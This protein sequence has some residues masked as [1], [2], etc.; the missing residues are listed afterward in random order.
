[1]NTESMSPN[2]KWL[3]KLR[4]NAIIKI[5]VIKYKVFLALNINRLIS[6]GKVY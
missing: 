2:G 6:D 5:N 3:F 1:M 4:S